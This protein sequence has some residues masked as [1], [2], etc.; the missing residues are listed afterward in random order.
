MRFGGE[1]ENQGSQQRG[2]DVG[3]HFEGWVGVRQVNDVGEIIPVRG[4]NM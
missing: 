2:G 1:G 3:I 4:N